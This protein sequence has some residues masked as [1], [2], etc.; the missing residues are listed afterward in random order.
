VCFLLGHT[1]THLHFLLVLTVDGL[2]PYN[3]Q[4][5]ST[6]VDLYLKCSSSL[7]EVFG[8]QIFGLNDGKNVKLP[9][10]AGEEGR[11]YSSSIFALPPRLSHQNLH[12]VASKPYEACMTIGPPMSDD[13]GA[14]WH[15]VQ[16]K[17]I[18]DTAGFVGPRFL[19]IRPQKQRVAQAAQMVMRSALRGS[20]IADTAGFVG[21]RFLIIRPQKQRMAQVAQM[22]MPSAS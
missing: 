11:T 17:V 6:R 10:Y 4:R 22:I 9:T 21:P 8:Y 2:I 1:E 5:D 7:P 13:R 15:S 19:I 16:D 3:G 12:R 20:M 14:D 18:A